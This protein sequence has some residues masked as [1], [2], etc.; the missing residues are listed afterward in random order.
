VVGDSTD[1][2]SMMLEADLSVYIDN[3][4]EKCYSDAKYSADFVCKDLEEL[5]TLLL[6]HGTVNKRALSEVIFYSIYRNLI[7]VLVQTFFLLF[8]KQNP[9]SFKVFS[10]RNST[11][12]VVYT[13]LP[14]LAAGLYFKAFSGKEILENPAIYNEP[15]QK[16]GK[17]K[18]RLAL[19]GIGASAHALIVSGCFCIYMHLAG[20][21]VEK[22]FEDYRAYL[23]IAVVLTAC[24]KISLTEGII[25][26]W[27]GSQLKPK[28]VLDRWM[29][30]TG[31]F[32][33]A[34]VLFIHLVPALRK[35]AEID[36]CEIDKSYFFLSLFLNLLF[37]VGIDLLWHIIEYALWLRSGEKRKQSQV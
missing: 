5:Q 22:D 15:R 14:A 37:A 1:D 31:A 6:V 12:Y 17:S 24:C 36:T 27:R 34:L 8:L 26:P 18:K 4:S 10:T 16:V 7:L 33:L 20:M 21:D 28:M 35:F 23:I 19:W 32:S 25:M 29:L 9:D 11:W 3:G 13:A 30:A 2:V